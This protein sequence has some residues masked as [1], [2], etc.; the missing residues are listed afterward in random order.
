[1]IPD[2]NGKK[3]SIYK[4]FLQFDHPKK[5]C[6]KYSKATARVATEK[7]NI[8]ISCKGEQES[9]RQTRTKRVITQIEER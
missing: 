2:E 1:M 3:N 4:I 6:E 5:F 8:C 9:R 7:K